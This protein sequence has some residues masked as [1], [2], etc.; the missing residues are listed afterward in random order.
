MRA[1]ALLSAEAF[2]NLPD[3]PGKQELLDGELIS[4]PPAKLTH[5]QIIKRLQELLQSVLPNSRV[6]VETGYQLGRRG[7]LQPDV[8]ISWPDQRVEN[9]WMQ[10]APMVAIEVISSS[11]RPEH[12][13]RKTAAYLDEGAAE[14][15]VVYPDTPSMTVFRK[16]SWERVTESYQARLLG[17]T[18]HLPTLIQP[19][20]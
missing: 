17:V 2:L 20:D 12:I 5:M 9:D 6:W 19:V 15:W 10:G 7:W 4:M 13:D 8:S 14:V 3:E 18:V 1:N 11:N 16:E